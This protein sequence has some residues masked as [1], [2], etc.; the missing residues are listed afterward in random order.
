MD[1]CLPVSTRLKLPVSV[2][3]A[4]ATSRKVFL[5]AKR[6][7]LR[8]DMDGKSAL[9]ADTCQQEFCVPGSAYPTG[10]HIMSTGITKRLAVA[11]NSA[12]RKRLGT[13]ISEIRAEK[14][15]SQVQLGDS[16]NISRLENGRQWLSEEQLLSLSDQF[17][18]PVWMIFA[19]ADGAINSELWEIMD[20]Y[21]N[22]APQDR[23]WLRYAVQ[24]IKKG[25]K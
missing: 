20:T 22:A 11:Q 25:R 18:V 15:L 23:A 10:L 1:L 19:R 16:G 14:G 2:P 7:R 12:L 13:A 4:S 17:G 3:T 21:I 24:T 6:K 8:G 5:R 9:Y